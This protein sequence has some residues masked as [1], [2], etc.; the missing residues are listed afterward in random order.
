MANPQA[1]VFN[2]SD[3]G[4]VTDRTSLNNERL[5][6]QVGG[7]FRSTNLVTAGVSGQIRLTYYASPAS[8]SASN[9]LALTSLTAG[10]Q[11]GITAGITNPDFP[12]IAR[13]VAAKSGMTPVA[14]NVVVHGTDVNGNSISDTI[15]LNDTTAV[16]GVKAFKTITS[17]DLP[18]RTN[19]TG[20]QVSVG[21]GAALGLQD[22]LQNNTVFAAFV[23]GAQES[24]A[25]TVVT[26]STDVSQNVVTT[27]TATAGHKV[28]IL[29]VAEYAS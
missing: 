14:G 28:V 25:P 7:Q 11:T 8:A 20:D 21:G 13:I 16:N 27:N 18:A 22:T 9:V 10:A 19:A 6:G 1:G 3:F 24:T 15:A 4:A 12:R 2:S 29:Y 26:N 23:N 5:T 17:I